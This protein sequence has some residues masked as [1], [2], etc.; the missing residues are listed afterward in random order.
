MVTQN[1][2]WTTVRR[3]QPEYATVITSSTAAFGLSSGSQQVVSAGSR[4]C[5]ANRYRPATSGPAAA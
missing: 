5:D 3:C 4:A 2:A 1:T